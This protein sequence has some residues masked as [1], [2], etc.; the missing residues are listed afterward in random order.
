MPKRKDLTGTPYN[1]PVYLRVPT[2]DGRME[3]VEVL[4]CNEIPAKQ[5]LKCTICETLC[6]YLGESAK[7]YIEHR[8]SK[9]CKKAERKL[10]EQINN[11]EVQEM[12]VTCGFKKADGGAAQAPPGTPDSN[13][14]D[15]YISSDVYLRFSSSSA[16]TNSFIV[17]VESSDGESCYVE[18][19]DD[20]FGPPEKPNP[21]HGQ[22]IFWEP[23]SIWSTYAFM[24]HE[25][26]RFSWKPI[27]LS[28]TTRRWPQPCTNVPIVCS[29]C[30]PSNPAASKVIPTI[31]KYNLRHHLTHHHLQQ[32]GSIAPI[33]PD[34]IVSSYITRDEEKAIGIELEKTM[35]F[36]ENVG[37]PG[38][39]DKQAIEEDLKRNRSDSTAQ[40]SPRANKRTKKK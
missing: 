16:G 38:S 13:D 9:P 33:P 14:N 7:Y 35:S 28:T 34:M 36:R 3:R 5:L 15:P 40:T 21:C 6:S 4:Q 39:D 18:A 20:D 22:R 19:Y 11:R 24:Q 17:V 32:D 12:L 10:L 29:L 31:W 37:M 30:L 27:G 26:D 2:D 23:G 8:K 25:D 1:K